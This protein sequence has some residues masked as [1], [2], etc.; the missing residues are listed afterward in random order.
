MDC[1]S[2]QVSYE[3]Y[4]YSS[5]GHLSHTFSPS[6]LLTISRAQSGRMDEQRCSIN[7]LSTGHMDN[8]QSGTVSQPA[9][10]FKLIANTQNGRLD[11]QR[12]TLNR[13]PEIKSPHGMTAQDSDQ[14]F[15]Q[16]FLNKM[17]KI[18]A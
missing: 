12:A 11:D 8:S 17:L 5:L 1:E 16:A 6:F 15:T 3:Y 7:P 2:F 18:T 13:L 14:L 10:F 9:K 4:I